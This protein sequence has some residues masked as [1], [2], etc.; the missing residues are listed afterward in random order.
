[1]ANVD[2]VVA[3]RSAT[4][5]VTVIFVFFGLVVAAVVSARLHCN[6]VQFCK[7]EVMLRCNC[8]LHFAGGTFAGL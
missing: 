8:C 5:L 1:M 7:G 6:T 2:V 4:G 3:L